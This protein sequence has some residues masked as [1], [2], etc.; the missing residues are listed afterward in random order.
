MLIGFQRPSIIYSPVEIGLLL[1]KIK[2]K[3]F[4]DF[5]YTE[6]SEE[7]E[8]YPCQAVSYGEKSHGHCLNFVMFLIITVNNMLIE[9]IW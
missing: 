8:N 1:V 3:F 4:F 2:I 6:F 7:S 5:Y 9:K